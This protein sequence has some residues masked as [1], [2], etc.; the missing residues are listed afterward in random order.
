MTVTW[1]DREVVIDIHDPEQ[2]A[3]LL[4]SVAQDHSY[5]RG[6]PE[7]L[8][9]KQRETLWPI[10]EDH[11]ARHRSDWKNHTITLDQQ[12]RRSLKADLLAQ[13]AVKP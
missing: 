8:T 1:S 4:V 10:V 12:E 3:D 9:R 11:L 6:N 7:G 2:V 13:M 5:D